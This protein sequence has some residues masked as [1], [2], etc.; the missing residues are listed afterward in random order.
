M[1][2]RSLAFR[3]W[4]LAW[5]YPLELRR[6]AAPWIRLHGRPFGQNRSATMFRA[7]PCSRYALAAARTRAKPPVEST[8]RS[9]TSSASLSKP[10]FTTLTYVPSAPRSSKVHSTRDGFSESTSHSM[11]IRLS[12]SNANTR[13]VVEASYRS[14]YQFTEPSATNGP[15]VRLKPKLRN[16]IWIHEGVKH[17]RHRSTNE[18]LDLRNNLVVEGHLLLGPSFCIRCV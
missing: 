8:T 14:Q 18:Q 16:H 5:S 10:L 9:I 7:T 6:K 4:L 13:T 2:P 12:C 11:Y 3:V 1:K 15:E 17:L